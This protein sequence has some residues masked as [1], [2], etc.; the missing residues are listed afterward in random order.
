MLSFRATCRW[1]HRCSWA[2]DIR[3]RRVTAE[4]M[5]IPD[6]E[7]KEKEEEEE[8]EEEEEGDDT[9][10]P[11]EKSYPVMCQTLGNFI[12]HF[13]TPTEEAEEEAEGPMCV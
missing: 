5:P 1:V 4:S 7:E 6:E 2:G 8:E 11:R 9:D 10:W 3:L 13:A 12:V